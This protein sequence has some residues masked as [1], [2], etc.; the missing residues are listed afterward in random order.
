MSKTIVALFNEKNEAE[1]ARQDLLR[2]GLQSDG[3][4]VEE[5][6]SGDIDSRFKNLKSI[7]MPERHAEAYCEGLRRGGGLLI[8]NVEDTNVAS[9]RQILQQEGAVNVDQRIRMWEQDGWDGFDSKARPFSKEE[10]E[11]ERRAC[12]MNSGMSTTS[13]AGSSRPTSAGNAGMANQPAAGRDTNMNRDM[14]DRESMTIPVVEEDINISKRQ[15]EGGGVRVKQ[16]VTE[17]PVEEKITLRDEHVNVERKKVD[18]P[19]SSADARNMKDQ[20]IEVTEHHEEPVISKEARV[21]E[22]I[23]VNKTSEQHTETVRDT[24]RTSDVEVEKFNPSDRGRASNPDNLSGRSD[25]RRK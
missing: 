13:S 18:R 25:L 14:N 24:V 3:I 19:I 21:K 23:K 20:V 4:R 10:A 16:H 22:E 1:R 12:A 17:K 2:T 15:T 9:A 11:Q 6:S 7:G 5:Y 8:A